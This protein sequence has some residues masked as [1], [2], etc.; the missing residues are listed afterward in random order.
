MYRKDE[1]SIVTFDPSKP[2]PKAVRDLIAKEAEKRGKA[3]STD[4]RRRDTNG[5]EARRV[6]PGRDDASR[7]RPQASPGGQGEGGD[8]SGS[9]DGANRSSER[10]VGL[11]GEGGDCSGSRDG[12][13]WSSERPAGF[14]GGSGATTTGSAPR[15]HTGRRDRSG[16]GLRP[17]S[18]RSPLRL[19]PVSMEI[20]GESP[21]LSP[22]HPDSWG[23][24]AASP[25]PC[26]E[27]PKQMPPPSPRTLQHERLSQR[28]LWIQEHPPVS[29]R[30]A[31]GPLIVT[32]LGMGG[33]RSPPHTSHQSRSPQPARAGYGGGGLRPHSEASPRPTAWHGAR[34]STA[35]ASSRRP[36]TAAA[37]RTPSPPPDPLELATPRQRRACNRPPSPERPMYFTTGRPASG[38]VEHLR[39]IKR[40][41]GS[42]LLPLTLQSEPTLLRASK[43]QPVAGPDRPHGTAGGSVGGRLV[44]DG[45]SSA[46]MLSVSW[47][48]KTGTW[49][50]LPLTAPADA[51]GAADGGGGEFTGM[52]SFLSGSDDDEDAGGDLAPESLQPPSFSMTARGVVDFTGVGG[53]RDSGGAVTRRPPPLVVPGEST[54]NP[55]SASRR[56]GSRRQRGGSGGARSGQPASAADGLASDTSAHALRILLGGNAGCETGDLEPWA[57]SSSQPVS[58]HDPALMGRPTSA[59][60]SFIAHAGGSWMGDDSDALKG[61]SAGLVRAVPRGASEQEASI[62]L[63]LPWA[64]RPAA[65]LLQ[66]QQDQQKRQL[67]ASPQPYPIP[68]RGQG[69]A[70]SSFPGPHGHEHMLFVPPSPQQQHLPQ[71]LWSQRRGVSPRAE[72]SVAP[73]RGGARDRVPNNKRGSPPF[74][75][76]VRPDRLPEAERSL[77]GGGLFVDARPRRAGL[78]VGMDGT[79]GTPLLYLS[80]LRSGAAGPPAMIPAQPPQTTPAAPGGGAL[81]GRRR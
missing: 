40:I 12:V 49:T 59:A 62:L 13:N 43:M 15:L 78:V 17:P 67:Q 22:K 3:G 28:D 37:M 70:T 66:Q 5:A 33:P 8:R 14:Q 20:F 29:A 44:A 81:G 35:R 72:R 48:Y 31:M 21:P 32:R 42:H 39:G 46:D 30:T 69:L 54:D 79:K 68:P 26:V 19:R 50:S 1:S 57:D 36:A 55:K 9:R 27:P 47:A 58:P 18:S 61:E 51:K 74:V 76:R 45:E 23:A 63:Q 60:D 64:G 7:R 52:G 71:Q 56:V 38:R 25:R 16:S 2:Q 65:A 75:K 34:A 10:A 53:D 24:R 73:P 80:V 41:G 6:P 77:K 4:S 11:Q